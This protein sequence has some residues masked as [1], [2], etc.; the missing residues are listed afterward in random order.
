MRIL[1]F[2]DSIAWGQWDTEGGWVQRL[3]RDIAKEHVKNNDPPTAGDRIYNL[4]VGFNTTYQ[5]MQRLPA[6][7]EARKFPGEFGFIFATG[8]NDSRVSQGGGISSPEQYAKDLASLYETARVYA[9]KMLFVGL[10]PVRDNPL[11]HSIWH[12]E[13]VWPFELALRAFTQ[14]K[15]VPFV[16]LYELFDEKLSAGQKLLHDGVH[17]TSEGHELMYKHIKPA[18]D[19]LRG[20]KQPT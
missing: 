19:A 14:E 11:I 17:P 18:C 8:L 7:T 5:V 6:E 20:I 1:C 2:G 13:R 15:N 3:A 10:T 16:P 12:A 9:E 4:G